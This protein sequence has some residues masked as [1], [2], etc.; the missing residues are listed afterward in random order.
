M[1]LPVQHWPRL[2]R[3]AANLLA[4]LGHPLN[5]VSGPQDFVCSAYISGVFHSG[6]HIDR[7]AL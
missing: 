4:S 3:H 6:K 1:F 2:A 7:L 5:Q